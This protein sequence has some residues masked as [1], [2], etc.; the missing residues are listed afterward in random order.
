MTGWRR[1]SIRSKAIALLLAGALLPL[2][3]ISALAVRDVRRIRG[4]IVDVSTLLASIVAEYSAVDL[5]FEDPEAAEKS[6]RGLAAV[7]MVQAAVLYDGEGKRFAT[8]T[9]PGL[10]RGAVIPAA[11]EVPPESRAKVAG[12]QVEVYRP[13]EYDGTRWGTLLLWSSAAPM[14]DRVNEYLW[15][16]ALVTFA[17]V[18][19]CLIMAILLRRGITRPILAVT[20]VAQR[21]AEEEDYE[22]RV[23][24][25]GP[26]E[27]GVLAQAFN[28][29]L[30]ETGRRQRETREA[31]RARD[32]FLTIAAHE[33]KTPLTSLKLQQQFLAGLPPEESETRQRGLELVD[34]QIKRLEKLVG[35]LLD[36]SRITAGRLELERSELDLAPLVREV[37]HRFERDLARSGSTVTVTTAPVTGTWDPLRLDQVVTN[38]VSNA[39]KYGAG[40]PID[41]TVEAAG[42]TARLVVRDRGI[43]IDAADLERIFGRFERAVSMYHFGG[44]GLG[45]YITRQIVEAHGGTIRAEPAPT[46]GSIFIVELPRDV[47][48]HP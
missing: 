20:R 33:L 43:G 17:V 8:Y 12:D 23:A 16:M 24:H 22:I 34:R 9:G 45:L 3:V 21:L 40:Q 1:A 6:L 13:V 18:A 26:D 46:A 32:D 11:I 2:T 28:R 31:I 27:I 48:P 19:G 37:V 42:A 10:P 15:G 25:A 30:A 39:I 4:R 14:R 5:A 41:V 47:R 44:M 36:V 38:L 35:D 29:M 7:D